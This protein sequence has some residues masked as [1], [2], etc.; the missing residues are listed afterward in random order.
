MLLKLYQV[1]AFCPGVFQGNAAGVVPLDAWLPDATMQAIAMENNQAETAFFIPAAP[2]EPFDFH[3]RWFTP[4]LEM[5]LCGHATLAAAHVLTRHM[6]CARDA[7]RF[8]SR[9]GIL[10]VGRDGDRLV[11]DFPSRPGERQPVTLEVTQALGASPAELYL[12]RDVMA[13]FGSEA[14]VRSLSPDI[15]RVAALDAFAV[16][17]TAPGDE[18]DFVSRFF[19]PK[20]GVP[21]DPAT[22]S[23]HCTLTP[24]WADRLGK[25]DLHA[26]QL[27]RRG[28][29]FF[30]RYLGDRVHIAGHAVTYL[31]G[32]IHV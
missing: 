3:L 2:A 29:E 22:G 28:G 13:V 21:E 26:L 11:L 23:S 14:E 25:N 17:A 7:V 1:D 16:I 9:S 18:V 12:A 24:Y 30:C 20:A 5:D 8:H 19:A 10:A 32:T 27:S 15:G 31:E 6:G 4:V